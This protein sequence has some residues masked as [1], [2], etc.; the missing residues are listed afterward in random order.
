MWAV[1]EGTEVVHRPSVQRLDIVFDPDERIISRQPTPTV[2]S[3]CCWRCRR[4]GRDGES[5][6]QH[7]L[8]AL[9]FGRGP[10][11]CSGFRDDEAIELT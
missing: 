2:F 1:R 9:S 10:R 4:S 11:P 8:I 7:A 3:R 6:R 5:A